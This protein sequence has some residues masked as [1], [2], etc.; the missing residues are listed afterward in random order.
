M[1]KSF[2]YL[3]LFLGILTLGS[4]GFLVHRIS[5]QLAVYALPKKMQSFFYQNTD[6]LVLHSVRPD[7]RRNTDPTEAPKHYIDFEVYGDSAAWKMPETWEE[8]KAK[9]SADTLKKYGTLPW[10]VAEIQVKLTDAFRQ[11]N[12]D[13]ILYY[14]TEIC[15]YV[16]DAHVPL[17]TSLNYDGQL[18][19]QRGIHALWESTLP[20]IDLADYQLY[21][22][23]K[24]KHLKNPQHQIWV[25]LQNTNLLL[26]SVLEEEKKASEMVAKSDKFVTKTG[27]GGKPYQAY[28]GI[29]AKAYSKKLEKTVEQQVIKT[30]QHVADFWFTAWKDA[31]C[32]DLRN[33]TTLKPEEKQQLKIEKIEYKTNHLLAKGMLRAKKQKGE[34]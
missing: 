4:W 34:D 23:Y 9:Y 17:H 12:K 29:F 14:A 5:A 28:S 2:A 15:H 24:A 30:G 6:Y 10:R 18:S 1:K 13:S 21:A 33:M 8:A 3:L 27:R 11:Q 22:K 7:Q 31:E 25:I 32:P 16:G 19:G 26:K 20:E